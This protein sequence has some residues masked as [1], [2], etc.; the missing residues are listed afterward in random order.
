MKK[1][2]LKPTNLGQIKNSPLITNIYRNWKSRFSALTFCLSGFSAYRL[3]Y[4]PHF[5]I[6]HSLI[7]VQKQKTE[8]YCWTHH[9]HRERASWKTFTLYTNQD[10]NTTVNTINLIV[11]RLSRARRVALHCRVTMTFPSGQT[12]KKSFVIVIYSKVHIFDTWVQYD[13]EISECYC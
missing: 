11:I 3:S 12:R 6:N 7:L 5:Y 2:K 8:K 1:L 13:D 9:I 4:N 10:G